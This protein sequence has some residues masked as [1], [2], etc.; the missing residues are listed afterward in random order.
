[1]LAVFGHG[2]P[3]DL[4]VLLAQEINDTL[5]GMRMLG[6]FAGYDLLD[7]EFDRLGGQVVA[8]AAGDARVEKVFD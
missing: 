8:V 5:V 6:I 2:A 7:L 4:D 3:G 1:L